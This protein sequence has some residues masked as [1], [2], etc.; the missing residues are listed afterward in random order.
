MRASRC[1]T[2]LDA[3]Q[4]K[5]VHELLSK[6]LPDADRE[7]LAKVEQRR[8]EAELQRF[9]A[10]AVSEGVPPA[11]SAEPPSES[12]VEN[13][14]HVAQRV[15]DDQGLAPAVDALVA[16]ISTDDIDAALGT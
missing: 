14:G 9:A 10:L 3:K 4:R 7:R 8:Q 6:G 5:R 13:L 15:L 12:A 1:S 2:L 16:I 11:S